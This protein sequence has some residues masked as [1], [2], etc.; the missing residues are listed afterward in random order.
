MFHNLYHQPNNYGNCNIL[1][2]QY[3][4]IYIIY[5]YEHAYLKMVPMNHAV[6][7]NGDIIFIYYRLKLGLLLRL[8]DGIRVM[9]TFPMDWFLFAQETVMKH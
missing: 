8:A 5:K 7:K 6:I 4:Y 9:M 2:Y 1:E 3:I